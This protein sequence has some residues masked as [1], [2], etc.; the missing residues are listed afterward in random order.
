VYLGW[1]YFVDT[2]GGVALGVG[3]VVIAAWGT[4]HQ[5]RRRQPE[6]APASLSA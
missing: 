1:H 6:R 5:L 2:I 3:G 4:G